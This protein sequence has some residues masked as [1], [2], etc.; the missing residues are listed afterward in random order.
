MPVEFRCATLTGRGCL[1]DVS[2]C[3]AC[4]EEVDRRPLV[5]DRLRL[6]FGPG[7]SEYG[8]WV[9]AEVVRHTVTGGFAVKF[10]DVDVRVMGILRRLMPK[11]T[12]P[13]PDLD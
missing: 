4:V 2:L 9:P 3:G 8:S 12:D 7:S 1:Q 10:H 11:P 6:V 5:G 13:S